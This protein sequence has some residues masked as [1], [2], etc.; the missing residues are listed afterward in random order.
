MLQTIVVI[1]IAV[2]IATIGDILMAT[3][4]KSLGEVQVRDWA[5]F[6]AVVKRVWATPRI[7]VAVGLMISFF[8][9][10]LSVLSWV[11]LSLALPMTAMTYVLNAILA[12]PLMGEEVSVRRWVG[13]IIIF[14]GVV[15]VTLSG[16]GH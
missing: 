16:Q 10:W 4:V 11:D 8:V 9:L 5:S 7:F 2:V 1:S 13:T 14:L 3:G 12:K 15:A 6:V